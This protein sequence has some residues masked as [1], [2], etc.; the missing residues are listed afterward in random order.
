MQDILTT[1]VTSLVAFLKTVPGWLLAFSPLLLVLLIGVLIWVTLRAMPRSRTQVVMPEGRPEIQWDDIAGAEEAKLELR[2]IVEFLK[3][4]E[5]FE[6]LGA[7]VPRGVML[8]GPPG[9]GKTLL[10]KAVAGES[11]AMFYSQS[12]SQFVEMFAGLGAARIRKLFETA[13]KNQP[14]IIFVDE[15]DAVG[16]K[17]GFDIS[18]EKDQTLNQLLVELDGFANRDQLVFIG[19]T[20]RLDDLDPALLRPG[21]C[22]RQIFVGPPDLDGRFEILKVHTRNKPLDEDVDL[23]QVARHSAGLAGADLANICNEAAI[24]AGRRGKQVVHQE[25]FDQAIE[26]VVAGLQ[27]SKVITDSEKEIVAYHE[28]GHALISDLLPHLSP[29]A[30]ITIV[31]RGQALGYVINLPEEDKY[32]RSREE[33]EDR[34]VMALGGRAAEEIVFGRITTGA[35]SDL[36]KVTE[37]ARSMVFDWGMGDSVG[38]YT[39]RA[40][41]YALSEETKERRDREQHEL[42]D[43]AYQR[44]LDL[45]NEHRDQ[46]QALAQALLEYEVLD[47]DEFRLVLEGKPLDKDPIGKRTDGKEPHGTDD[48]RDADD[49][50]LQEEASP[51]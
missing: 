36:Q 34:M 18:R 47:R 16:T 4:P 51:A 50:E 9:T 46:L 41:N 13:R 38:S 29:V 42:A 3:N 5:Q 26:R 17:R 1:F 8:Y 35:A 25:D 49:A 21:R 39:L 12:A 7:R 30:K 10:A 45:L 31:P 23:M 20:N 44:A 6:Q 24:F 27:S 14:A 2:E 22:D 28:A 37:I 19:A 48:E 33:L 11:G 32:L 43:R 15:M 40:D